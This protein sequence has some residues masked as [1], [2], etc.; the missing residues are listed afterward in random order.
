MARLTQHSNIRARTEYAFLTRTHHYGFDLRVLEAKA[1]HGVS[2]L[3][4]DPKIVRVRL[5]LIAGKESAGLV[6]IHEHMGDWPIERQPPMPIL[7]WVGT[8]IDHEH[9][10][11]L[12]WARDYPTQSVGSEGQ[13][14]RNRRCVT[15]DAPAQN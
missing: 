10:S 6:N 7:V 3:D 1:L 8:E 12:E 9:R 15:F 2:K 13:C 4:V 11:S 5:Q 14:D